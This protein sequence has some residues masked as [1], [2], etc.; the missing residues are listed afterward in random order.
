MLNHVVGKRPLI[1]WY[2]FYSTTYIDGLRSA[3]K[4]SELVL[5]TN[6]DI[7]LDEA[8]QKVNGRIDFSPPYTNFWI[9]DFQKDWTKPKT[10]IQH[11]KPLHDFIDN[12]VQTE[13]ASLEP[14]TRA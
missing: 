10:W 1:G 4:S 7:P 11:V 12:A 9:V 13:R 5:M 8:F 3:K 2:G 14:A 6:F